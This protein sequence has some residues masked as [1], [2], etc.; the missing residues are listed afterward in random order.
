MF[1]L[2]IHGNGLSGEIGVFSSLSK[3]KSYMEG[4]IEKIKQVGGE[5]VQLTDNYGAVVFCEV[6]NMEV[7]HYD[8][9]CIYLEVPRRVLGWTPWGGMEEFKVFEKELSVFD[10]FA[11]DVF[12]EDPV[13]LDAVKDILKI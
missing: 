2:T 11:L 9:N 1:L 13:A 6:E 7:Y 12:N 10:R 3:V 8:L 4:I 5:S